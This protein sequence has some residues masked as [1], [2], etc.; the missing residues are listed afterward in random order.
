MKKI[1]SFVV[2]AMAA[3]SLVGCVKNSYLEEN[4]GIEFKSISQKSTKGIISTAVFPVDETFKVWSWFSTDNFATQSS[5]AMSD[6]VI[7]YV[8]TDGDSA[9]DTWKNTT[10]SYYWPVSGKICFFGLYPSSLTPTVTYA[11]GISLS[12]YTISNSNKTVDLMF[13]SVVGER[14]A[15]ALPIVFS[16]ALSQIDFK[17]KMADDY[18]DV[19]F[20]VDKLVVNNID[21]SGDFVQ[22]ATPTWSDNTAQT[23]NFDYYTTQSAALTTTAVEYGSPILMIPQNMSTVAGAETQITIDYTITQNSVSTSGVVSTK[24][25]TDWAI[26]KKYIYTIKFALYEIT[27]APTVEA[28]S[29]SV[30]GDITLPNL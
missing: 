21:L 11:D 1:V 16:H 29:E 9:G 8:D 19:T 4:N 5:F 14:R 13:A 24:I 23:S 26:G 6:V 17:F 12:D 25:S 18:S 2:V 30:V 22:K 28:W 7:S 15:T 27:F 10:T 3:I 20:K